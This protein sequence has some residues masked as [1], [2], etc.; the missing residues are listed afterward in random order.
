MK[1]I[2]ES[3]SGSLA[4]SNGVIDCGG[5]KSCGSN[6]LSGGSGHGD[7]SCRPDCHEKKVKLLSMQEEVCIHLL[8]GVL[9]CC[10]ALLCFLG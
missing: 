6:D 1:G 2:E 7:Q 8:F 4:P 5:S 9:V 10:F 3:E